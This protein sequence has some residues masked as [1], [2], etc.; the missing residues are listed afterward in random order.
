MGGSLCLK[1]LNK[2]LT[3]R[4]YSGFDVYRMKDEYS[5]PHW[6]SNLRNLDECG[7]V[8]FHLYL[9]EAKSLIHVEIFLCQ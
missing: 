7:V 1:L 2:N 6:L 8:S 5:G 9:T 4:L 3:L